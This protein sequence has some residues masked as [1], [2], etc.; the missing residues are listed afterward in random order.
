M[1]QL[2]LSHELRHHADRLLNGRLRVNAMLVIKID[3]FN[4]EAAQGPFAGL[5]HIL[6]A[7]VHAK[8]RAVL[9]P[10]IAEFGGEH[11]AIAA[12]PDSVP[13]EFLVPADPIHVGGVEEGDSE[14]NRT[15]DRRDRLRLIAAA[16]EFRH[17][18]AA[19]PE[20]GNLK[21]AKMALVHDHRSLWNQTNSRPTTHN[22][23]SV[24]WTL[25][26]GS[27]DNGFATKRRSPLQI[28]ALHRSA[29]SSIRWR[30][31]FEKELII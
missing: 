4:A 3:R 9:A 22:S 25:F 6:G 16:V 2:A 26:E 31:L 17:A 14:L 7:T 27:I 18:H 30:S 23:S 15:M 1:A 10:H 13:D 5:A 28:L 24:F 29:N 21:A 11:D 20:G 19:K 12:V 8:K